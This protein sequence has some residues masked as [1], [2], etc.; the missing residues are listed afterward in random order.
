VTNIL[1]SFHDIYLDTWDIWSRLR[2]YGVFMN[3]DSFGRSGR[4][5]SLSP[6]KFEHNTIAFRYTSIMLDIVHYLRQLYI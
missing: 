5:P 2:K 6:R 3:L 1:I 4:C